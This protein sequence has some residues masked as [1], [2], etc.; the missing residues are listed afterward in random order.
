MPAQLLNQP[1]D[2]REVYIFASPS[3]GIGQRVTV[4]SEIDELVNQLNLSIATLRTDSET[5]DT[6]ISTDLQAA[7]QAVQDDVNAR[8][9]GVKSSYTVAYAVPTFADLNT[10]LAGLDV[11][12]TDWHSW[13]LVHSE[14][15]RNG[16]YRYLG[17]SWSRVPEFSTVDSL[18]AGVEFFDDNGDTYWLVNQDAIPVSA[19]NNAIASVQLI[20]Y[21]RVERLSFG[22][23]LA[24]EGDN[25]S[26]RFNPR[27]F[28]S[29]LIDGSQHLNF[30]DQFRGELDQLAQVQPQLQGQI[31]QVNQQ[32]TNFNNTIAQIDQRLVTAEAS[33]TDLNATVAVH[34][35]SLTDLSV[36]INDKLDASQLDIAQEAKLADLVKEFTLAGG[37]GGVNR[38]TE[39]RL[40]PDDGMQ[41]YFT[42][43]EGST[44]WGHL[45]FRGF[46]L[47]DTLAPFSRRGDSY[48]F[49]RVGVDSFRIMFQ[50]RNGFFPDNRT[51]IALIRMPGKST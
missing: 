29:T 18:T 8:W 17:G 14:P 24:K 48:V 35:N 16:V 45:K 50:S 5:V 10:G 28:Q 46:D 42:T 21:G 34:S 47:S 51:S 33:I 32:L 12:A 6:Q 9:Q 37:V 4:R 15:A 19:T 22:D 27:Y 40:D 3:E 11:N 25:V 20:P 36:Q 38:T 2:A 31:D 1:L 23:V 41:Y 49:Q 30:S 26:L 43:Y 39:E 44:G 7:I 13:V